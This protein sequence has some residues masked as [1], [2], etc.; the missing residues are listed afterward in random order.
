M[1]THVV[2]CEDLCERVY[3]TKRYDADYALADVHKHMVIIL[4]GNPICDYIYIHMHKLVT[5]CEKI[6][7]RKMYHFGIAPR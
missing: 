4:P 3:F 7:N 6:A 5:K 2:V 1:L